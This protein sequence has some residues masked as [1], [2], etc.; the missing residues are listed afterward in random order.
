MS[1]INYFAIV[2]SSVKDEDELVKEFFDTKT[3]NWVDA[4]NN[5]CRIYNIETAKSI[6]NELLSEME[7]SERFGKTLISIDIYSAVE[8]ET[9]ISLTK[10]FG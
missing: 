9:T 7:P 2:K 8:A 10:Y 6:L 3:R 5:E 1:K 4:F